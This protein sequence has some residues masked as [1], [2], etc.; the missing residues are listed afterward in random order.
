[1]SFELHQG[2][3]IKVMRSMP[4]ES[5]DSIVT[6]PPYAEQRKSTYGGI[7]EADYPAWTVAWMTEAWRVLKPNGSVLINIRPHV[8]NGQISDYVLRT[9]LALRESGWAE[10]EELIWDKKGGAPMGHT[11]RPAGHGNPFCGSG[12]MAASSVT[13]KRQAPRPRG[14]GWQ[15][16]ERDRTST[17][18]KTP[19]SRARLA[20]PTSQ[21]LAPARTRTTTS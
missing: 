8:R 4:A 11:G 13:Q 16:G 9:R 7:P 2:D 3:C 10:I 6:S 19:P 14:S 15:A 20:C 12:S 21:P 17:A 5:V 18:N 1:M